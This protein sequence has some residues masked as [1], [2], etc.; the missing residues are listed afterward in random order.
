MVRTT[1]NHGVLGFTRD[2]N[3]L[4]KWDTPGS[5]NP[6]APCKGQRSNSPFDA[7]RKGRSKDAVQQDDDEDIAGADEVVDEMYDR[8]V[9]WISILARIPICSRKHV[10]SV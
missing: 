3:W 10:E 2:P 6:I 1:N 4:F 9:T 7:T 8:Q 5:S